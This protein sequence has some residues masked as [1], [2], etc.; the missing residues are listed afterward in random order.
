M[1]GIPQDALRA[2]QVN[3][4]ICSGNESPLMTHYMIIAEELITQSP[5]QE[6]HL[7]LHYVSLA[8]VAKLISV[9]ACLTCF[10]SNV[11]L[12]VNNGLILMTRDR[13]IVEHAKIA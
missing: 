12:E 3:Q 9:R 2:L 4:E 6:L 13:D 7:Q 5:R 10:R 8:Y 1:D 11:E